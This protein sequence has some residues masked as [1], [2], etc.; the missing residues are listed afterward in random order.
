M[1]RGTL[2]GARAAPSSQHD[3]STGVHRASTPRGARRHGL[4]RVLVLAVPLTMAAVGA[5]MNA[6]LLFPALA[7]CAAADAELSGHGGDGRPGSTGT[8]PRSPV[9]VGAGGG[10]DD[11]VGAPPAR[12]D[13][14]V[15]ALD[16][17]TTVGTERAAD[18][19]S[20]STA[21]GLPRR[22]RRQRGVASVATAAGYGDSAG[23]T[24]ATVE[25]GGASPATA[26]RPAADAP[27][28]RRAPRRRARPGAAVVDPADAAPSAPSP[29]P[30]RPCTGNPFV[31]RP[32]SADERARIARGAARWRAY[33]DAVR[34]RR[35]ALV[36]QRVW[37]S[38]LRPSAGCIGGALVR[39]GGGPRRS[40]DGGKWV[41][42]QRACVNRRAHVT[43]PLSSKARETPHLMRPLRVRVSPCDRAMIPTTV[44]S[45]PSYSEPR[46]AA[47]TP[48]PRPRPARQLC[49]LGALTHGCTI[50]SLGSNGD[51]S[52]ERAM[53]KATPCEV[54]TFDCTVDRARVPARLHPR[55]NFHRVCLGDADDVTDDSGRKFMTLPTLARRNG[56]ARIDLLKVRSCPG[57]V[58]RA[59]EVA[60]R[61]RG[62]RYCSHGSCCVMPLPCVHCVGAMSGSAQHPCHLHCAAHAAARVRAV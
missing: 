37:G 21:V 53:V 35:E 3:G 4:W 62:T 38:L 23:G 40:G 20:S 39:Y 10:G 54:H 55:I 58:W 30:G 28:V 61:E 33:V 47:H 60:E 5:G 46:S 9:A 41:R 32:W 1:E 2:E 25:A 13:R 17:A 44:V 18:A 24:T 57:L 27:G 14:R 31:P 52:F 15:P 26:P 51:F 19:A 45:P 42:G 34:S 8:R 6:C 49:N 11:P 16:P 43:A 36:L 12:R 22:R 56:H 59:A 50:Y 29:P 48:H 7:R